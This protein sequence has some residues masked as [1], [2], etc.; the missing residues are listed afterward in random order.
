[1]PKLSSPFDQ[2]RQWRPQMRVE[3]LA[4][5]A[6]LY[7]A[8]ACNGL[9]W[10]SALVGRSLAQAHTWLLVGSL[11]V[12]ITAIHFI[13]LV[14]VLNRWTAKPLLGLL[15]LGTAFA[16]YYMRSFTVFLDPSML[17]NVLRTDVK[18]ATELFTFG[19]LPPLLLLAGVPLLLLV[20]IR[21]RIDGWRRSLLIRVL[22]LVL[23]L[24][25]GAGALLAGFQ[26]I[27]PLM[28][29]HKEVRYLITPAN[30]LYSL[31]RV[32]STDV[33]AAAQ[34]RVQIGLDAKLADS[35]QQRT[36]PALFVIV[37]GETAR[38]A[39][40][41]ELDGEMDENDGLQA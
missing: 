39:I 13:L 27:A 1:M 20:R 6:S 33:N 41:N 8:L 35:W 37:V 21:L 40:L 2:L 29:N 38:A 34:P 22:T 16:T 30:Y 26:Q 31:A 32:L 12:T 28:R 18:E 14:L 11:F 5:L 36:K 3:T 17:R 9:F 25:A 7:F 4:L 15:L 10:Q 24:V 19:M 23:A